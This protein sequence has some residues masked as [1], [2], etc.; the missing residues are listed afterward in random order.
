M[1]TYQQKTIAK[2]VVDSFVEELKAILER[3]DY[4]AYRREIINPRYKDIFFGYVHDSATGMT[5]HV[6]YRDPEGKIIRL[7]EPIDLG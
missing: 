7:K 3:E 2:A 6:Q 4:Q 5:L 1:N